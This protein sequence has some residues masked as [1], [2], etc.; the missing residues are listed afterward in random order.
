MQKEVNAGDLMRILRM[1]EDDVNAVGGVEVL[2]ASLLR[3]DDTLLHKVLEMGRARF[4]SEGSVDESTADTVVSKGFRGFLQ[5]MQPSQ[6]GCGCGCGSGGCGED[7]PSSEG[8]SASK[9]T[10]AP[11]NVVVNEQGE[12]YVQVSLAGFDKDDVSVNIKQGHL[13]VNAKRETD[14]DGEYLLEEFNT[15]A[16]EVVINLDQLPPVTVD[17]AV[18]KFIEG[19]LIVRFLPARAKREAVTKLL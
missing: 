6:D 11:T 5:A 14:K 4:A 8:K 17:G 15:D 7:V 19:L 1:V 18:T 2:K 9:I 10:S 16:V 13:V 12:V 3:G